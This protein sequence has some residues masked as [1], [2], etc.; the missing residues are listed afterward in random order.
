[1]ETDQHDVPV[2]HYELLYV[3]PVKYTADELG[4]VNE[5][6]RAIVAEHGG[7]ITYEDSL[8]KRKLAYPINDIH[9]GYYFIAE[10]NAKTDQ[11]ASLNTA[12]RLAPEVLRHLIVAKQEPTAAERSKDKERRERAAAMLAEAALKPLD[13]TPA[14]DAPK[15]ALAKKADTK[16]DMEALDKKLDELID[17]S[18][19]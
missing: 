19:L 12:L 6:V 2:K 17:T 5:R 15:K 11:L 4:P 14:A 7:I 9:H 8:G 1:M 10:F 16:V 13:A 18:I 3:I